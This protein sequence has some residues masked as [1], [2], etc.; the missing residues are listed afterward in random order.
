MKESQE[1]T[2]SLQ[3]WF[4]FSFTNFHT[5]LS[6]PSSVVC[7][8]LQGSWLLTRLWSSSISWWLGSTESAARQSRNA[9]PTSPMCSW[10][11]ARKWRRWRSALKVIARDNSAIA[12]LSFRLSI[13]TIKN[14]KKKRTK[15]TQISSLKKRESKS[16]KNVKN[17]LRDIGKD[18]PG[19]GLTG[20]PFRDQIW[21]VHDHSTRIFFRRLMHC[22]EPFQLVWSF[23]RRLQLCRF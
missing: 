8:C 10:K 13:N 6:S 23:L 7:G 19:E 15:K 1:I 3:L 22:F 4:F 21:R 16:C 14:P 17:L 18:K 5:L 20:W 11:A 9:L 2:T 12:S